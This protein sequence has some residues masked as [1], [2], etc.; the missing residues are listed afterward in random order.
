M[1]NVVVFIYKLHVD[2][3]TL[4]ASVF[5]QGCLFAP[6]DNFTQNFSNA[7]LSLG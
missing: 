5:C 1:T 4:D 2:I 6:F 7:Q 3:G